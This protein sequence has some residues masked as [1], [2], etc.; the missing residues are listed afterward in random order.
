MK[1]RDIKRRHVAFGRK[2]R[3]INSMPLLE[4]LDALAYYAAR[5]IHV[6]MRRKPAGRPA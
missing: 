5:G 2:V 3:Y 1:A 4:L 6:R